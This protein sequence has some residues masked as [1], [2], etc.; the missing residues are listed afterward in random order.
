VS[1]MDHAAA[2]ERIEDL[3]L[4]PARLAGLGTSSD[5]EDLALREHLDACPAC[6]ADLEAWRSVQRR[7]AGAL[8]PSLGEAR[9][10]VEPVDVPPSLRTAV[11]AAIR[12]DAAA[13]SS[14]GAT[15][16]AAPATR[17]PRRREPVA[18][19]WLALAASLVV[20]VGATVM[21][22]DQAGRRA[23]AEAEAAALA[24]LAAAMDEVLAAQHKIVT[25]RHPD[26]AAA[27]SISWSRH[28]WVVLTKALPAPAAGQTYLC[29]LEDGGRSVPVGEMEFAGGTAYWVATL[30]DWQTWEIED[31]TRFVV[32]LEHGNPPSRTGEVVLSA[33]LGS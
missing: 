12:A 4:E 27:G 26:G 14:Q 16:A 5:S 24:T 21:T 17:Q 18:R 33:E 29:W 10:A 8:P 3:L 20:L 25:L 9:A 2:H 28:D 1:A 22:V 31:T 7:I 32:S 23:A 19:T 11:A 15:A 6:R 30:D 13:A